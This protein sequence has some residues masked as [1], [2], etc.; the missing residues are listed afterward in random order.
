MNN[1]SKMTEKKILRYTGADLMDFADISSA[2]YQNARIKAGMLTRQVGDQTITYPD[3]IDLL[4]TQEQEYHLRN[5][6][7]LNR[8]R[9]NF[10]PMHVDTLLHSTVSQY[11]TNTNTN[12]SNYVNVGYG[13]YF[14]RT[15][16]TIEEGDEYFYINCTFDL[17]IDDRLTTARAGALGVNDN[18][19]LINPQ[20]GGRAIPSTS[21]DDTQLTQLASRLSGRSTPSRS[22]RNNPYNRHNIRQQQNIPKSANARTEL[23]RFL[24]RDRFPHIKETAMRK[25]RVLNALHSCVAIK[26]TMK[27]SKEKDDTSKNI[28]LNH[29]WFYSTRL[30]TA[31]RSARLMQYSKGVDYSM[32]IVGNGVA[33]KRHTMRFAGFIG[34]DNRYLVANII[35][36]DEVP[37]DLCSILKRKVAKKNYPDTKSMRLLSVNAL[38][39]TYTNDEFKDD[40]I[41]I[42]NILPP[43]SN[44]TLVRI[45]EYEAGRTGDTLSQYCVISDG[46][47]EVNI[48]TPSFLRRDKKKMKLEPGKYAVCVQENETDL[49]KYNE[50]VGKALVDIIVEPVKTRLSITKGLSGS[51]KLKVKL[52]KRAALQKG[53]APTKSKGKTNKGIRATS[54]AGIIFGKSQKKGDTVVVDDEE[55]ETLE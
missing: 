38:L 47:Y 43:E 16:V 48:P 45:G 36:T 53:S 8:V 5:S 27:L 10:V 2:I 9:N 54:R 14:H 3:V 4:T 41:D 15:Q 31:L 50:I 25:N 39:A 11:R 49:I 29:P 1:N 40:V 6:A 30:T 23:R 21:E 24:I 55:R 32:Q 7:D 17:Y 26:K 42:T 12:Q 44:L 35:S 13:L 52:S 51:G 18:S 33:N 19:Y 20:V 37:D 46:V 28:I 34:E 22:R